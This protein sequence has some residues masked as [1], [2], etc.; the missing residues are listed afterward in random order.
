MQLTRTGDPICG[1]NGMQEEEY[2]YV[3]KHSRS[4]VI[5]VRSGKILMERV[6]YFGREFYTVPGGGIEEGELPEQAALQ[7]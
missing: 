1:G 6:V 2:K 7:E 3:Y 5:V 4:V